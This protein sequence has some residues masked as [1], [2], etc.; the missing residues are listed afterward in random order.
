MRSG[1]VRPRDRGRQSTGD[2]AVPY[3]GSPIYNGPEVQI[4]DVRVD[5]VAIY[6]P[7]ASGRSA[8]AAG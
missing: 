2:T 3:S 1:V 8:A 5:G 4:G 6:T 7:S